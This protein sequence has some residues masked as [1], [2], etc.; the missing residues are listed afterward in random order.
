MDINEQ[1]KKIIIKIWNLIKSYLSVQEK[2]QNMSL[3]FF[4]YHVRWKMSL[5]P[6]TEYPRTTAAMNLKEL[7]GST[8]PWM[9]QF[10][11]WSTSLTFPRPPMVRTTARF[12][13]EGIT[14]RY[15]AQNKKKENVVG[16]QPVTCKWSYTLAVITRPTIRLEQPVTDPLEA[17]K[18]LCPGSTW[19]SS[20]PEPPGA[21]LWPGGAF[22]HS[23]SS[24]TKHRVLLTVLGLPPIL[25]KKMSL[26]PS[27]FLGN[28]LKRQKRKGGAFHP[29]RTPYFL[30]GSQFIGW[31]SSIHLFLLNVC[32]LGCCKIKWQEA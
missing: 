30:F 17:A 31:L 3:F 8:P 14:N 1:S 28:S 23:V 13:E 32:F 22:D 4:R 18:L 7:T 2:H 25:P 16:K 10:S 21:I 12:R 5:I 19:R 20:C 11:V 9:S 15:N 24:Y 29:P 27:S 26:S 6:P